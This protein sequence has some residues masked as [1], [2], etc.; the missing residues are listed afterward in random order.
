LAVVSTNVQIWCLFALYGLHLAMIQ[1]LLL[2]LV[3]RAVEPYR[4][5]TALSLFNLTVGVTLLIANL[6][7]GWCWQTVGS[8]FT[9]A[10]GAFFACIATLILL[11][12]S[13]E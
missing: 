13:E 2:D 8:G 11:I 4:R 12:G 3:D 7:A 6:I 9:F 10:I 5:G 1:G